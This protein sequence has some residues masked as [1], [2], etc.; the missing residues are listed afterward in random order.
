MTHCLRGIDNM[1]TKDKQESYKKLTQRYKQNAVKTPLEMALLQTGHEIEINHE[2]HEPLHQS[3]P[4]NT[5]FLH[6]CEIQKK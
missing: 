6:L 4:A 3:T 5:N 2:K 1:P